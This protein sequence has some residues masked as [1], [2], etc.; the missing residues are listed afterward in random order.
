MIFPHRLRSLIPDKNW[1]NLLT[2]QDRLLSLLD[3]HYTLLHLLT[4]TPIKSPGPGLPLATTLSP[5]HITFRARYVPSTQGLLSELPQGRLCPDLPRSQF[6]CQCKPTITT[7]GKGKGDGLGEVITQ[8][9]NLQNNRGETSCARLS[10]SE[11]VKLEFNSYGKEDNFY[12]AEVEVLVELESEQGVEMKDKDS[13]IRLKGLIDQDIKSGMLTIVVNEMGDTTRG[14]MECI[15][16][17]DTQE[18]SRK[19]AGKYVVRV[20]EGYGGRL[21]SL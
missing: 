7:L 2:N 11:V 17:F 19:E 15:Q 12:R 18:E 5:T 6:L 8:W 21:D 16:Q 4:T 14:K 1:Q 13:K 9:W 10:L 20:R 3:L